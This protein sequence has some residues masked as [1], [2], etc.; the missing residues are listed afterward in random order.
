MAQHPIPSDLGQR[1]YAAYGGA[2][3]GLTHDGYPLPPW[4]D[5]A[6]QTQRAWTAA[7]L[8]AWTAALTEGTPR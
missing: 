6:E 4:G 8:A 2:T 3:G 5:L 1:T 7:G